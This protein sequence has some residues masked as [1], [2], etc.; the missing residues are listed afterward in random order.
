[1][2]K[3]NF[4]PYTE[5]Q[6]LKEQLEQMKSDI[7]ERDERI[8]AL[9][10]SRKQNVIIVNKRDIISVIDNK[11]L[12]NVFGYYAANGKIRDNNTDYKTVNGYI[13]TLFNCAIRHVIPTIKDNAK[14]RI[15]VKRLCD[16]SNEEYELAIDTFKAIIDT[17]DYAKNKAKEAKITTTEDEKE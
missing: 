5:I 9:E 6:A 14:G 12:Y 13:N 8:K 1:M 16:M 4:N 15:I 10:A 2:G 17:L 11:K 7:A 3:Y